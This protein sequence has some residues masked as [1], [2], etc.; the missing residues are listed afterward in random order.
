[1]ETKIDAVQFAEALPDILDRVRQRGERF[2]IAF[3]GEPIANLAPAAVEPGN[4]WREL[5]EALREIPWP[6]ED[7]AKDLED[8]RAVQ[9]PARIPEW[10]DR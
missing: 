10:L 2:V 1:M 4:T 7:F 9:P 3:E 6:D 8:I 5:T